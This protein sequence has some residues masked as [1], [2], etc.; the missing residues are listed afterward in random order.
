MRRGHHRF[1]RLRVVHVVEYPR[2][3]RSR[4]AGQG[5]ADGLLDCFIRLGRA[6]ARALGSPS[7]PIA[8]MPHPFG[9]RTREEVRDIAAKCADDL[10][11]AR[12]RRYGEMTAPEHQMRAATFEVSRRS[13]R[14]QQALQEAALE[15][16]TA[17][18]SADDGARSNACCATPAA[19]ATTSSRRSR[20]LTGAATVER[21]AINAVMAGC[22][23]EYLPVLIA[24]VEAVADAGVQSAGH[25]G[26][27]QPGR[28]SG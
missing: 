9:M 15:R 17:D 5:R 19:R 21:I 24:A 6:Q 4:E 2:Q 13:R 26:D 16:R 14:D 12:E 18:R 3:C 25:A 27:D 20:R 11:P 22:D 10:V 8:V 23:P 7:F 28:R 1:R